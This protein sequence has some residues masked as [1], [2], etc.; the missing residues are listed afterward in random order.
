[1]FYDIK[2]NE[3]WVPSSQGY[4]YIFL[5]SS[6]FSVIKEKPVKNIQSNGI[7][8]RKL[9]PPQLHFPRDNHLNSLF[10]ILLL[11]I[12]TPFPPLKWCRNLNS[13]LMDISV[14]YHYLLWQ[15]RLQM[16]ILYACILA[17]LSYYLD[18]VNY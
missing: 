16:T 15:V 4:T 11:D 14:V 12:K 10:Q 18:R 7:I 8:R 9:E 2:V 6:C 1:M 17:P 13:L 3:T 5:N